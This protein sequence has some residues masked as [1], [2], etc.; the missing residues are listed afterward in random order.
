MIPL[1]SKQDEDPYQGYAYGYPHKTAYRPL[2]PSIPLKPRWDREDKKSL[3][4]YLHLPFCEMRCG[5]CN[6]FTTTHPNE[7]MVSAYLATVGRQMQVMA[8][9]L[10]DHHFSQAAFGGGT[11]SFLAMPE[12]ERLF[13]DIDQTLG[14]FAPETPI[15]FE[16]SPATV[17]REKLSFLR[18][19]GVTRLSIGV[20]SFVINETKALGRP[21]KED[22]LH[23]ALSLIS[24]T[25]FPVFN[26]DL[27]Y[28]VQGQTPESWQ[29]SLDQ[30]MR[31]QPQE[32]YLYPLYVRPLT[33]LGKREKLPGDHRLEL[34]T[35][36]RDFL[37]SRGYDQISMRLFRHQSAPV[38]K[39]E[40]PVHCCQEDGMVGLG[41][42]SRSYT[43]NL[44][45]SSE[46]AV[47][48]RGIMEILKHYIESSDDDFR[49]ATYGCQLNDSDLR[50]RFFIKSILRRGG[51]DYTHYGREFRSD[52]REDFSDEHRE[53]I[54]NRFARDHGDSLQ[55]TSK[56]FAYSDLIGPW[57]FSDEILDKMESYELV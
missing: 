26:I 56:G 12:L 9:I 49:Q 25:K 14:P 33:G 3:F 45:Y 50:R 5:F 57:L 30:A 8:D 29:V 37:L 15:S 32:L 51:L 4:F 10:G 55:L 11:P 18:E 43:R 38:S 53:L 1:S 21:Q 48:R 17:D 36:A 20:Q 19:R 41:A 47:G 52:P 7:G 40:G 23:R 39:N 42:G 31:Y 13:T 16:T 2:E 24:A 35:Q 28:G 34:Y 6:L 46:Y 22:T 54:Q 44:H 27:I